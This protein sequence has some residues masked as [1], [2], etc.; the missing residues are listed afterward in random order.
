MTS[1]SILG[2]IRAALN[3]INAAIPNIE[4]HLTCVQQ[5]QIVIMPQKKK[6]R[7]ITVVCLLKM[8]NRLKMMLV[9]LEI[10]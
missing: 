5:C 4:A 3:F 1:P 8:K 7:K 9:P 2:K 6:M 10:I